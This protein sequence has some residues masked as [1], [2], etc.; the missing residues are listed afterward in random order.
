MVRA[1]A[2]RLTVTMTSR[3]W[4]VETETAPSTEGVTARQTTGACLVL[5]DAIN[6]ALLPSYTRL[7][8]PCRQCGRR[9]TRIMVIF[10]RDC[11]AVCGDH[12][13]RHCLTCGGRSRERCQP[14]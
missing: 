2:R 4:V 5:P 8:P 9:G 10:D 12:Y 6:E 3:Q 13:H 1:T 7:H 11:E 14:A